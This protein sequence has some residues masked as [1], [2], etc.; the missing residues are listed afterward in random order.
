MQFALA[1]ASTIIITGRSITALEETK[2]IIQADTPNC[3]ILPISADAIDETSVQQLFD[4]L[5][6]T[7]D[8]LINNAGVSMS[9]TGIMN[10]S[11][12]LWWSDWVR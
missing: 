2:T 7:P 12:D 5:P 8:V 1:G 4:R 6:G 10:S 9:Q 11:I 3:I